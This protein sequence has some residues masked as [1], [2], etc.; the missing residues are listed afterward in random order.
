MKKFLL[1]TAFLFP[2]LSISQVIVFRDKSTL[3]SLN[4]VVITSDLENVSVVSD[5]RGRADISVFKES[6]FI[7]V[8]FIGYFGESTSFGDL[9]GK[10]VFYLTESSYFL[11]ELVVS[12]AKFDEKA[13]DIPQQVQVV[14]RND[15]KFQSQQTSADVLQQTGNVFVQKS[16]MGG[17]SP[18]LRGFEAN[19]VLIVVDGIRMNNAIY[20]GGHLQDVITIDNNMLE[21]VEVVFGPGSVVYGSDAL[22]GVMH[23][24]TRNPIY[25]PD[26]VKLIKGGAYMRF[27]SANNENTVH[28]DFQLSGKRWGSVTSITYSNFGDLRQGNSRNPFIQDY[29][30]R[31]EY[32][33][34]F[35]GRDSILKN[36]NPNIQ[37]GTAYQQ[38]D[39]FHKLGFKPSKYVEHILNIQ[40]STSSDVP[41]YDRLSQYRNGRLRWAEWYYGPQWRILTA[42]EVRWS[43]KNKMFDQA[44]IIGSRQQIEQTRHTRLFGN[45]WKTSQIEEVEV[46]AINADFAK[47]LPGRNEFRYGAEYAYNDVISTARM[48]NINSSD[49]QKAP[50]RYPD[51][52]SQMQSAAL[53]A[54]HAWEISDRW[55]LSDGIRFNYVRLDALFDDKSFFPFPFSEATQSHQAVNGNLGV[56]F[57]PRH[58]WKFSLVA[59]SGFR[60][61]NV[62][63]LA[64]VFETS[65]PVT[66]AQGNTLERGNLIVPNPNLKPELT[67]NVDLGVSKVIENKVT[68]STTAFYTSYRNALT[69][70]P[71]LLNESSVVLFD[72]DSSNVVTMMNT[73]TA[74][75][76]GGSAQLTANVTKAFS[77]SSTLNYTYAR[78][79]EAGEET[80]L[81]HIPPL[82]GKT[83]FNLQLKRFR[84]EFFVMYNGWKRIE[85]YRLGAEDNEA[86]ATEFGMPAWYTLNIR[87]STQLH[88]KLMLQVAL[89]NILDANYRTF[90]SNVSAPGRNLMITL[91]GSF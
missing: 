33:E 40:V 3:E 69:I 85:D 47:L 56:V 6:N 45:P 70:G 17:G 63:D 15:M 67:Y 88:E 21:K 32:V 91:R 90:S 66:D 22:G 42:Y 58:H 23:F 34:T 13:S 48:E 82:Y 84:G 1:I 29:W 80:P 18:V 35:N 31:N 53:Y 81:D 59:S 28:A 25:S 2:L 24:H 43:K 87:T 61:P 4:G 12:A 8:Q 60:A 30:R 83:S 26:S 76:Y 44:R 50:T 49:Q 65:G 36:D 16:Q 20:R 74:Y 55:I 71:S 9:K 57:S 86:F 19:K 78:I 52:G 72:G 27:S 89:E 37:V 41:R 75:L 7:S 73:A 77:M 14:S 11:K 46:L 51:G 5:V 39:F 38:Y 68:V 62:D 79:N 10:G 64:K 54:T